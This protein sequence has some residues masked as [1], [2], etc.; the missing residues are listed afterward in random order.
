MAKDE[1]IIIAVILQIIEKGVGWSSVMHR[2]GWKKVYLQLKL[3][4]FDVD[5]YHGDFCMPLLSIA[6]QLQ[7]F[8]HL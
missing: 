1:A 7:S 6:N 4:T 8:N 3:F 2:N 5:S